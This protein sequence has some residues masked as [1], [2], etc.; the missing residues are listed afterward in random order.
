MTQLEKL[1]KLLGLEDDNKDFALGF[2]IARVKD[3]I[4]NYCHITEVP[5]ELENV[6]L[7]VAMDLYRAE[8]L[9]A[10]EASQTVK[11]IT[12]GDTTTS[13]Q[14]GGGKEYLEGFLKDFR[15]QLEPFRRVGW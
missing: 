9:G 1:K 12:V 2:C 3:S 5:V 14:S 4:K 8:N 10:A 7:S 15:A 11:S 6:V 13:F